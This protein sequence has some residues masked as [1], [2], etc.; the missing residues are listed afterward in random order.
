MIDRQEKH[1]DLVHPVIII[2][3]K[4]TGPSEKPRERT[5][6]YQI[7]LASESPRR[8]EIMETMGISY[9]VIPSNVKEEVEETVP[10]QMVQALAK[11]KTDAIKELARAQGKGDQD[12]I[13]LGADTMVFYQEHALGKPKNETDAA[14]MLRLLSGDV[15]EVCTGVSIHILKRNGEEE[16]FTF[17]VSTKVV[18]NPLT[19][20]QIRDYIATGE[21]M[22]KAGAY[23]IQGKFGIFIKEIDGDYY[24]IVGFPIAEIYATML[25]H[26]I[27]LKKIN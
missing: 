25:R 9:L 17:A 19:E 22:D 26:G 1:K 8:K 12:L 6:M 13:I 20:E 21:P 3:Y 14:R 23:A 2:Y 15:H 11:L 24:N 7:I 18:V 16:S 4:E 5:I 27:D 10:D